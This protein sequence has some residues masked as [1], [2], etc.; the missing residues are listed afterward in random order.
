VFIASLHSNGR[1]TSL[2][3]EFIGALL[4]A[5]Q[6]AVNTRTSIVAQSHFEISAF[7]QLRMV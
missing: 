4:V 2:A 3:G 1:F 5:Q 6:R 7:Q